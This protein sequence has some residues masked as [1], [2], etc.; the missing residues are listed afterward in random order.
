M[1]FAV[2]D[3]SM[4]GGFVDAVISK[5]GVNALLEIKTPKGLKTA[6][7][8]LRPAQVEFQA[9]WKGPIITAY[10]ASEIVT[11]FNRLLKLKGWS[12]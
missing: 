8:R 9:G 7:Q 12:K 10:S 6:L 4:V 2:Q 1:G 5:H 11:D 3:T